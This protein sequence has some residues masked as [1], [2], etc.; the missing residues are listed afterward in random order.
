VNTPKGAMEHQ[1][2]I[3]YPTSLSQR[4]DTVNYVGIHE[5]A[6]QWFGDLVSPQDFRH[7]WLTESFAT[8]AESLW[9]EELFGRSGYLQAQTDKIQRYINTDS[10]N[11]GV[12]PI[13]DFNRSS[14]SS[15]YP[16][17]IYQKGAAVVG[18]LRYELGDSV[19]YQALRDYLT[20]YAYQ[21][22]T[23]GMMQ[24]VLEE[25]AGRSLDWFFDQWIYGKGWPR[26]N[27]TVDRHQQGHTIGA[28]V[29]I[30]QVQDPQ[31]GIYTN[32]PVEIGFQT[33]STTVYRLVNV[34]QATETFTLDTLPDFIG[35]TFNRGPTVRALLQVGSI[36][37]VEAM[38]QD[39]GQI[40]F[41]VRPNPA[42]EVNALTVLVEGLS[43]CNGIGYEMYDTSGRR[44]LVGTSDN[45]EFVIPITGF[46]SAAYIL[47][48]KHNGTYYDVPISIAR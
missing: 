36:T 40:R 10:R 21:T 19:F 35:V 45:C 25:H 12:F 4:R 1:T 37:R 15:N 32:L 16:G 39:S 24:S 43:E 18:M 3:S 20:R 8:Y 23:T 38:L 28:S 46:P 7:T 2:M 13:Y 42:S 26:L 30:E 48:F 9:S 14:P 31:Y 41:K 17:T 11:E 34:T 6:H 33:A 22:A 29:H 27:I 44:L 5:L 47:R